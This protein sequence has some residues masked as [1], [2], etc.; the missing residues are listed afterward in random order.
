MKTNKFQFTIGVTPGYFHNNEKVDS[1]FIKIVDNC[2]RD[3]EELHDIYIS[4]N[5]IH[6]IT[7]YKSEW[8]CPDG[9][10]NTYTLSAI[11]NPKFNDDST[12]WKSTCVAIVDKLKKE[13]N[14]TTVT[15]EFSEVDFL[16]WI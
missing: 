8:G 1:D 5:I 13:L 7:L 2:A 11:R 10:E 12:K 14:Q 3:V 15:G 6:T 9:G 4:F 16:Y